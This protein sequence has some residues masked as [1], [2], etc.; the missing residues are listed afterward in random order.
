LVQGTG[1]AATQIS[2][3]GKAAPPKPPATPN[4]AV[5]VSA[6]IPQAQIVDPSLS[7]PYNRA[8]TPGGIDYGGSTSTYASFLAEAPLAK[9]WK[10]LPVVGAEPIY[11]ECLSEAQV[12]KLTKAHVALKWYS[13]FKGEAALGSVKFP[14]TWSRGTATVTPGIA[15]VTPGTL[16]RVFSIYDTTTGVLSPFAKK[17]TR[18]DYTCQFETRTITPLV[19]ER[20]TGSHFTAFVYWGFPFDAKGVQVEPAET[21]K[22]AAIAAKQRNGGVLNAYEAYEAAS[23]PIKEA[24][25]V[26]VEALLVGKLVKL[27]ALASETVAGKSSAVTGGAELLESVAELAHKAK[28]VEE[29]KGLIAGLLSKEYN[30]AAMV[31]NGHFTT[32]VGLTT[33]R[34]AVT[35]DKFP[36]YYLNV[37]RYGQSLPWETT[38]SVKVENPF[39]SLPDG[40]VNSSATGGSYATGAQ[41]VT[42]ILADTS[43]FP[44]IQQSLYLFGNI[45]WGFDNGVTQKMYQP[46]PGNPHTIGWR[47]LDGK[48]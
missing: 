14:L 40:V 34:I 48:P 41:A 23:E 16:T 22:I 25:N 6:K 4:Y 18:K 7:A 46:L 33:L 17:V 42:K 19:I 45:K 20:T 38:G 39:S 5:Q 28:D 29:L 9:L 2:L 15:T 31:V 44:S 43:Q 30:G 1:R 32:S 12:E 35:S 21:N 24:I 27:P 3:G 10:V 13:Y 26:W 8:T 47:F 37:S 36:D 11:P